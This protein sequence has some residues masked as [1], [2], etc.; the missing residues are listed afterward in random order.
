MIMTVT[1]GNKIYI[2]KI[3]NKNKTACIPFKLLPKAANYSMWPSD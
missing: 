1:Q 2:T 3:K